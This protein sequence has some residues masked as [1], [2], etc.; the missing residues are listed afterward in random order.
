M[1]IDWPT[2]A[3]IYAVCGCLWAA[4]S[5]YYGMRHADT[6]LMRMVQK[7]AEVM[8]MTRRELFVSVLIGAVLQGI[9]WPILAAVRTYLW[10]T[11]TR[12]RKKLAM[13]MHPRLIELRKAMSGREGQ[14]R[15]VLAEHDLDTMIPVIDAID[16]ERLQ[17][18]SDVDIDVDILVRTAM[19]YTHYRY[20]LS[21]GGR[22]NWK[23]ALHIRQ[24]VAEETPALIDA[25]RCVGTLITGAVHG[26][27]PQHDYD[28][29][30]ESFPVSIRTDV[31]TADFVYDTFNVMRPFEVREIYNIKYRGRAKP[32]PGDAATLNE[33]LTT[34]PGWP[35]RLPSPTLNLS[36]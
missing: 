7:H 2:I 4:G 33:V 34:T 36:S 9:V 16:M 25:S 6:P 26:W 32:H 17:Q 28:W 19:A 23:Q 30:K 15:T 20:L 21:A 8:A 5:I 1:S 14:Y 12:R 35:G 10:L 11:V 27:L 3:P 13:D 18:K 31:S 22:A 24:Q 29:A